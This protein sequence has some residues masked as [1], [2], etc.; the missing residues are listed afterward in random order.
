MMISNIV[1]MPT[2]VALL[3]LQVLRQALDKRARVKGQE[4]ADS[5]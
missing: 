4:Q 5:E 1:R 2:Q 3:M